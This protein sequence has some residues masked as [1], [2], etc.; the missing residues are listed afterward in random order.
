MILETNKRFGL[1]MKDH[2]FELPLNYCGES[3]EMI[4][5][6]AREVVDEAKDNSDLP[7]LVYFQGGPGYAA[8]RPA[9]RSG[10]LKKASEKY[11]ILLLDQRGTGQSSV[12]NVQTLARFETAQEKADYLKNFRA[13]NI[14]RDA[15]MIRH[16]LVGQ[17]WSALGQSFGG[18]CIM[19]YLSAYPEAL[20]EAF[21]TG[22]VPS[23]T[24]NIDE[25][26][27]ETYSRAKSKTD[28]YYSCYPN[29]REKVKKIAQ[30]IDQNE[31]VLP[32]GDPLSVR[33][34]QL[35][36]SSLGFA[37][38]VDAIHYA[39]ESA[40]VEG[41]DG[42]EL[43]YGF[44][45]TMENDCSFDTNPFY[46]ILHEAIYAQGY[47]TN[48]SA[49]R[50]RK[51]DPAFDALDEEVIWNGEMVGPWIFEEY[52]SLASL[53]ETAQILAEYKDW[54]ELYDMEVL[55]KNEVPIAAAVYYNDFFV[56]QQ[57]S[58]ETVNAIPNMQAFVTSEYEHCGIRAGGERVFAKLQDLVAGTV[59]R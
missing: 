4:K 57:F 31:V 17:K 55:E 30:F 19:H 56:P 10:W 46:A 5:I 24:R 28:F 35:L 49:E 14:I 58:M 23:M 16:E 11:R 15:E 18:F 45:R 51:Q 44:L 22:G 27:T 1:L 39:I 8:P 38:G 34:F 6:F 32:N 40:F 43:S 2:Q 20:K 47:A 53:K 52:K 59:D 13:D 26:Y 3:T 48:W 50:I 25:L 42:E 41:V 29:D 37:H 54:P 21:I 12:V 7:W 36:G 9:A 33:R